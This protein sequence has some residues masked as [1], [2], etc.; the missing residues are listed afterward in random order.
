MRLGYSVTKRHS[1][2]LCEFEFSE[3]PVSSTALQLSFRQNTMHC[4]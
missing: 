3:R 4:G 2:Q 1:V